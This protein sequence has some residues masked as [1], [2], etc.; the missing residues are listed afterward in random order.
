MIHEKTKKN[1]LEDKKKDTKNRQKL[2]VEE[3]EARVAM[4]VPTQKK[5]PLP[6]PYAPGSDYGL[7][8]RANLKEKEKEK[9]TKELTVE[10]LEARM[11]MS[12]PIQKKSPSPT[13]YAPGTLYGLVKRSSL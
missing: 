12:V 4:S 5:H 2:T 9:E 11:A 13:P 1:I 6:V 8:K 3:L 10:E 7:V